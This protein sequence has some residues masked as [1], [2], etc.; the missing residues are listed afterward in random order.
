MQNARR[1]AALA[2]RW[3]HRQCADAGSDS[4]QSAAEYRGNQNPF[5]TA[6]VAGKTARVPMLWLYADHDSFYTLSFVERGFAQF[7]S[8]GGRGALFEERHLPGEGHFLSAAP[9][10]WRPA[11]TTY[12]Q[13]VGPNR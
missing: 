8:A 12:L 11:V 10:Y 5:G 7:R 3:H 2:S 6:Q 9:E 4:D 13:Q 1:H